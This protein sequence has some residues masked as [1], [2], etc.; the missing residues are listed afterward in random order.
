[1][2]EWAIVLGTAFAVV[3]AVAVADAQPFP[4]AQRR[5]RFVLP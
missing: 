5:M 1:V 4:T 2:E 3:D